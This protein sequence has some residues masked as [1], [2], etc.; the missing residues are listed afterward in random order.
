METPVVILD[1]P[2]T[3]LDHR[4]CI[5]VMEIVKRLHENG[6][7]VVMVCHDMEVVADYAKRVIVMTGGRAIDDGPT[8]E[9]L[10][11]EETLDAADLLAPQVVA[12][13][14][15]MVRRNPA[16]ADT[17]VARANTL[18]E[19]TAAIAAMKGGER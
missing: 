16:L 5:K 19:M 18:D 14:M 17:P 3:G 8:F 13:S 7:T 1:E 6:A 15:E 12:I 10:R 4:E 2:T 11:R 9:V